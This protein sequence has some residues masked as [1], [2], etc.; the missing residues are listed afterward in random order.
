[1]SEQ[2]EEVEMVD[3]LDQLV[4]IVG[5][6]TG[7]KSA[8]LRNIPNQE[9]WVYF[10][11]EAG[12]RLPFK[13]KFNRVNVTDPVEVLDLFQECIDNPDDVDGIIIDS[14]TFLMDMYESQYVLGSANTMK[15]WGDYN[16]YFKR[17]LQELVPKF[18]KPVI[19][20]AH[21]METYDENSP[22]GAKS[23]VPIKGALKGQGVEAYFTTVVAAKR[24]PIKELE[25]YTNGMLEITEEERELGFKYV[26]QTKHTKATTGDRIRSPMGMFSREETYIDN[27]AAKLLQH[28]NSFYNED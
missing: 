2:N 28:L 18:G 7:G 1:M 9:R 8:S 15:S 26:F 17:I 5:Q 21:A 22:T 10:G 24:V 25:K 27:D 11:T 16:Q 19:I 6:S 4:L 12:K 13:N 23:S 14:L 20:I 3:G